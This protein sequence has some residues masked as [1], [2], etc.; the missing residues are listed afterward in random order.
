MEFRARETGRSDIVCLCVRA[1]VCTLEVGYGTP[2]KKKWYSL[3]IREDTEASSAI[4]LPTPPHLCLRASQKV[5]LRSFLGPS[6]CLC[7]ASSGDFVAGADWRHTY[8]ADTNPT[9]SAGMESMC[10]VLARPPV[11]PRTTLKHN[12]VIHTLPVEVKTGVTFLELSLA[13]CFKTKDAPIL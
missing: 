13:V 9:A 11:K 2:T 7:A 1:R 10:C 6:H 4:S 12:W 8:C 3:W 5:L